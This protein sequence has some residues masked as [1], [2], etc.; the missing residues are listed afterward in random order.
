MTT[1]TKDNDVLTVVV[2]FHV[3]AEKQQELVDTIR[4]MIEAFTSKQSGLVSTNI[5]R[6]EDGTRVLN[7]AQWESREYYEAFKQNPDGKA[8]VKRLGEL[9]EA[10]ESHVY[11]VA[12]VR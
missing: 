12:I 2:Y 10:E 6:S 1:I 7:Y 8:F 4:E 9:A 5:H 3:Q 11:E